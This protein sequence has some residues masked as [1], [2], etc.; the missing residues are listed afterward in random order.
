MKAPSAS[1]F[2]R[3]QALFDEA[4]D[5]FGHARER[6]VAGLQ[7]QEPE[8]AAELQALLRQHLKQEE[9]VTGQLQ[10]SLLEA[11]PEVVAAG[12]AIGPYT[13]TGEIGSGGMGRV[14]RAERRH[15]DFCQKVAIKLVRQELLNPELLKRFSVERRLLAELDHPGICRLIDIGSHAGTPYVVMELIEGQTLLESCDRQQLS[16]TAR[17]RLFRRVLAA[18]SHAH[19]HLVVHRDIKSGNILVDAHGQPRLLDFGIAKFLDADEASNTATADRYLSLPSAAPEQLL[20][21]RPTVACDVYG[22]G[23]VLYELLCGLPP[24]ARNQS[25]S[26]ELQQQILKVPPP[27]MRRRLGSLSA[28][29]A[30]WS[31]RGLSGV[32]ALQRKLDGELESIVQRCLRKA[33]GE[34]YGSVEQ[35][36]ED[37]ERVL[38]KRPIRAAG[39]Q[40][41]YVLRK[42]IA[43]HRLPAV[44]AG[45]LALAL[46]LIGV[47]L[48]ARNTVAIRERDRAREAL[49]ILREALLS[50]DPAR[51]AGEDVRVREVL[52][53]AL[54][55]L[56]QS[57]EQ[58]P[59]LYATVAGSIAEVQ[60]RI[61]LS[62][63]AAALFDRAAAAAA[64]SDLP[65]QERAEL[66]VLRARALHAAG[67]FERAGA[68][69]AEA[70]ASMTVPSPEWRIV[71]AML[72]GQQNDYAGAIVLLQQALV[73]QQGRSAQ[74]EWANSAR[75][76]LAE[77][78][79]NAGDH[80]AALRTLDETL[81]WQAAELAPDHPRIALTRLQ[82]ISQQ[83]A[84]GEGDAALSEARKVHADLAATYG[85]RSPFA[86]KAAMVLGNVLSSQERYA[87]AADAYSEVLEIFLQHLGEGH[88]NTLRARYNL[89]AMLATDPQG[90]AEALTLF[91]TALTTGEARLG[92]ASGTVT[93]F[94]YAYAETLLEAGQPQNAL[95]LLTSAG[96][97]AGLRAASPGNRMSSLELLSRVLEASPCDAPGVDLQ[98]ACRQARAL[99][100]GAAR[101]ASTATTQAPRR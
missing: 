49:Q 50:A 72:L 94:R 67:E 17:L 26:G 35:L 80:A 18:V 84:M 4:L 23:A 22:L 96:A 36:D 28:S 99:L 2:L 16:L 13:V 8:L 86:A 98:A 60:L 20:G 1:R 44:L 65:A 95:T 48:A 91:H 12:T 32:H 69:L 51:V 71:R 42:F 82:R 70:Q 39:G 46:V 87:E 64:R 100:G 38:D 62:T 53:T 90:R 47:S 56:E 52:E 31:A 77:A 41:L 59:D 88:P 25:H 14:F 85:A 24:F 45:L 79:K 11:L 34:R 30:P 55:V 76:R 58:Q 57:F 81:R 101:S 15:P 92:P 89:A 37:I 78:Q 6:F 68:S 54:P 29:A 75:L 73:L 33:P 83:L 63:P 3:L 97:L 27:S 9:V 61:G 93:V 5:H 19:R 40:R 7:V 43:R 74:D 10:E 21:L 66:L